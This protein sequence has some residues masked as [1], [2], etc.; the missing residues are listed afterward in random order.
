MTKTII[1]GERSEPQE[2]KKPIEF[3]KAIKSSTQN[4]NDAQLGPDYFMYVELIAK[5]VLDNYDIMYA[6]DCPDRRLGMPYLGH[7]NDGIV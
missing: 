7:W 3:I 6:Y 1:I 4:P 5:N 2:P